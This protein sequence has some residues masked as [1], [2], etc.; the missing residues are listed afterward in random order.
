MR[1]L[2]AAGLTLASQAN[3]VR[4]QV[5]ARAVANTYRIN[6]GDQIDIYVWGDERLQRSMSVLPD[7]SFAFPLAGT[8]AAAGRTPTEV[9]AELSKLLAPQYKGIAPQVTISVKV[10]SGMQIA[11]IGKVRTPGNFSPTRYTD[12]LG[13][14]TLA[15][16]PT[17]FADVGNI[18]VLRRQGD[19]TTIIRS[20][21]SNILKGHPAVEDLSSSAVPQLM[22]GDTVVVP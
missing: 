1:I 11:V 20:N 7:G 21:L 6:A 3:I 9:E 22:A 4:A 14:L 2:I 19:R 8:V 15:G 10:P 18:M 5:P 17:D 13:A 12:V 16:G